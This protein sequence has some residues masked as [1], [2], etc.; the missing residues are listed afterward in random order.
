MAEE[1]KVK[2]KRKERSV[3]GILPRLA[4]TLVHVQKSYSLLGKLAKAMYLYYGGS[5]SKREQFCTI[6][7][8]IDTFA[9]NSTRIGATSHHGAQAKGIGM[10]G[11]R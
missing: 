11:H 6:I 7:L 10:P 9:K 8:R 1:K 2:K 4:S 3:S 5:S